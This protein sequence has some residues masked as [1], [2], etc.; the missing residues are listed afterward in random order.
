MYTVSIINAN[1]PPHLNI[2]V[3]MRVFMQQLY[4]I[5]VYIGSNVTSQH[6]SHRPQG[7]PRRGLVLS[8]V[9]G[10]FGKVDQ[11]RIS[12]LFQ[13]VESFAHR[14]N[15]HGNKN[16][17]IAFQSDLDELLEADGE[18]RDNPS[19]PRLCTLLGSRTHSSLREA[20][21]AESTHKWLDLH[22]VFIGQRKAFQG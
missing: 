21:D 7:L 9:N 19:Q 1:T 20:G 3:D 18:Y 12:K 5:T 11:T 10:Q 13:A 2:H 4:T 16:P 22:P 15:P 17:N 14:D 8:P 6:T